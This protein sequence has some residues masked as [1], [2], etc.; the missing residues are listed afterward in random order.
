MDTLS[1]SGEVKQ[2]GYGF[3]LLLPFTDLRSDKTNPINDSVTP[4]TWEVV[5]V[6]PNGDAL[7]KTTSLTFP[8]NTKPEIAVPIDALDLDQRGTYWYQVT[9]TTGTIKERFNVGSFIVSASLPIDVSAA[10]ATSANQNYFPIYDAQ[11]ALIPSLLRVNV[12]VLEYNGVPLAG[13]QIAIGVAASDETTALTTGVAKVTFRFPFAFTL[14]EIRSNVNTAP[15]GST[16]IVDVNKNGATMMTVTKLSI[17][18]TEKTSV[19]A[20]SPAVLTTTAI[21]DDDEITVDIDQVGSTVAGKGLKLW[22]IG[23]KN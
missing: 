7:D 21:A 13:G 14:S 6:K 16:L 18:A 4:D 12:G 11:G 1:I 15:T 22:F 19:T 17:D 8:D 20:A 10:P 2:F 5:I 3:N 9:K 23:T